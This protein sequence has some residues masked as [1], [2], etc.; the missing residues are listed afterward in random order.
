M[1]TELGYTVTEI[2]F[3]TTGPRSLLA[4]TIQL[5]ASHILTP[6]ILMELS[7]V[8]TIL[9]SYSTSLVLCCQKM[10]G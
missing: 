8:L 10:L 1:G 9:S 5:P 2:C 3:L 7:S 4:V 6:E